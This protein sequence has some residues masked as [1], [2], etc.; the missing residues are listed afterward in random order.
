MHTTIQQK[1]VAHFR[2]GEEVWFNRSETQRSRAV[3][4]T[5]EMVDGFSDLY[6]GEFI[7]KTKKGLQCGSLIDKNGLWFH[8]DKGRCFRVQWKQVYGLIVE[9]HPREETE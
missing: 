5:D 1:I 4:V 9:T 3:P 6:I 7:C 2:E 8:P